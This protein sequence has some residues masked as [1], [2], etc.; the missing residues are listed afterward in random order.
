MEW[1]QLEYFETVAKLENVTESARR[2]SLSQPAL[3]RSLARLE[4]ELGVPLF[5][6]QGRS[7]R[8]TAYGR[9]FLSYVETGLNTLRQGQRRLEQMADPERGLVRLA[10]LPSFGVQLVPE[11]L[12]AYLRIRPNARFEL[13]QD[14]QNA[15]TRRLLD[16]EVDLLIASR[17][18]ETESKSVHWRTLGQ[19]ELWLIVPADHPLGALSAV[20]LIDIAG[21]PMIML[22]AGYGLRA[23]VDAAFERRGI[24]PR[25]VFEG[26]ELATVA[27]LVEAGLGLAI[28]PKM[29]LLNHYRIVS[30]PV[31]EEP[32]LGRVIG[33][34]WLASMPTVPAVARFR[35][36]V[37]DYYHLN[38][39]Q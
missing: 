23:L 12:R 11:L 28:V 19:E 35:D 24:A 2:L 16:G 36:F 21:E 9:V 29:P 7:I 31:R 22:K 37:L 5:R 20:G 33:L 32:P 8:L 4:E 27:G 15:L 13:V 38:E 6:R 39:E 1:Q 10:F 3:S 17:I 18:L 30:V 26:E 34:G 25:V 14:A